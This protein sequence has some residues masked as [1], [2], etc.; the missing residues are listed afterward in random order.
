MLQFAETTRFAGINISG[1]GNQQIIAAP[2]TGKR[3]RIDHINLMNTAACNLY[4][5]DGSSAFASMGAYSL[6]GH[7]GI[8]LEN[9]T[10]DEKGI[11]ELGDNNAFNINSDTATQISGFVKYR[12]YSE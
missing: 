8:I 6:A 12:I 7:Q 2:G 1:T 10:H 5:A 4:W 3:I 9:V 11:M